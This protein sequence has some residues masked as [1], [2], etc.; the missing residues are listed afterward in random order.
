MI[1]AG[2][3]L[4]KPPLLSFP[5]G[6]LFSIEC[7]DSIKFGSLQYVLQ[8]LLAVG[9]FQSICYLSGVACVLHKLSSDF[10]GVHSID[11]DY[12]PSVVHSSRVPLAW[13][14]GGMR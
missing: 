3:I 2:D 7:N 5:S 14:T 9:K 1:V 8:L 6:A 4:P 13:D 10:S 12:G 11:A